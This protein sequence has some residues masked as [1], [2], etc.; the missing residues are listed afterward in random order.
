M[1]S[2]GILLGAFLVISMCSL[3]SVALETKVYTLCE[4]NLSV[5]LTPDFRIVADKGTESPSD[6]F[7]Q[8]F[9]ITDSKSSGSAMLQVID[10]YDETITAL[11]PSM[12]SQLLANSVS[13]VASYLSVTGTDSENVIGN[14]STIDFL[15][16]NVTVNT[17]NT[18]GTPLNVF[19]K[20]ADIAY[21]NIGENKYAGL[22]SFFDKNTTQQII[23]TLELK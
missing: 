14:W 5:N 3:S 17:M 21:W 10:I 16:Q 13:T 8:V 4:H 2:G 12:V 15:G 6:T 23:N 19:G 7:M 1:R 20:T 22:I 11:N 18:K 9:M